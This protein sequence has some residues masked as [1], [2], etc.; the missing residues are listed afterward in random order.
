MLSDH[1]IARAAA[2]R[3]I[4]AIAGEL[5]IETG[6]QLPFGDDVCKVHMDALS[7]PARGK[8]QLILVSAT[9]PTA[10][11]EGKTTTSIGS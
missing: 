9:T 3:P 8:G 10:A 5:G 7:A 2:L 1:E 4:N 11:G 6:H